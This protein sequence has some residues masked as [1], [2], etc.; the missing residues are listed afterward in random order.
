MINMMDAIFMSRLVRDII[1]ID[2]PST[3]LM[4]QKVGD[5]KRE[6]MLVTS[7]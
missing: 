7:M 5:Y 2:D 3:T 1:V 6:K 4:D